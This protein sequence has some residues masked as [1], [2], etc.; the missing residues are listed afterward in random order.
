MSSTRPK[1]EAGDAADRIH[2]IRER[3][4]QANHAYYVDADPIMSDAEYDRVLDELI[5]LEAHHP[6][7]HDPNSPSQ[8]VGGEPIEGFQTVAHTVPMLSIDNTYFRREVDK[9][10]SDKAKD[11]VESWVARV[12]RSTDRTD[13]A[14]VTDPKI[15]GVAMSLRYE[16]GRLQRAVTRGDGERG[17]DVTHAARAIRSIP[18]LLRGEPP[19]VLE[20]RGELFFPRPEFERVNAE[21]EAAGLE[22]FMN[23]RNACAGTIKQLDPTAVSER[24]LRFVAH[25]RGEVSDS[26]APTYSGFL[27]AIRKMGLPTNSDARVCGCLDEILQAIDDFAARRSDLDHDTDGLVIRIDDFALQDEL[28][29]TSKSPRWVVAYKFASERAQ[30]TLIDVEHQVGKTGKIT[31]RAIMEPV[32]L[33]GTTVRHASLH[34]YGQV[35]QKDIH[36]GDT[37]T[38]E[39]AG[40]I[41]PYVVEAHADARPSD[42]RTIQPPATCPECGGP[43]EI[44]PMAEDGQPIDPANE[45]ARRCVNPEC[46]AQL[47]EKLIW[48]VGRDQMDI[49]GLGPQTIDQIRA[50]SDITLHTFADIFRLPEHR[51]ALLTLDRMGEKKVENLLTGIEASKDRGLERVLAGMGIR[52]VG[53][54]TSKA[55]CKRFPDID[56]I[57]EAD[58]RLL[59]PKTLNKTEAIE[60]GFDPDPRLR[61]ETGLG[62]TTAPIVHA[63]LNSPA[64][65]RTFDDL[66]AV[67]V[68][69][70]SRSYAPDADAPGADDS[71]FGGKT[72][73][74][75]GTLESFDRKELT[76]RLESLGAKVT[77]SVSKNTDLVIAGEKAGSK[78]DKANQLGVEVWDERRLLDALGATD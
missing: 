21:R 68:R 73:V 74:I 50:E 11:S 77:G 4:N 58:E 76:E 48:F 39:K 8:R 59:R 26:L 60:L 41:I 20:V 70:E 47:R 44:E 1:T 24:R 40:E 56:A 14:F 53:A 37:V 35:R 12:H 3:L 28:G 67:G 15:D 42:A 65:R 69:L 64:A 49:D 63:Y 2:S 54:A 72:V 46:P 23:P 13:V 62:K 31:P 5:A 17:D 57:I 61:P 29:Y 55:L 30:T 36:L 25:G 51:E 78:L 38:I 32:V 22:P 9:A 18:L 45:T 34:N 6:E 16:K 33:A 43:V 75:T 66:R 27:A 10:E 71:P 52:H 7:L 19:A